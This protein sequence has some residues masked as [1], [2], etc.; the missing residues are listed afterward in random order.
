MSSTTEGY[1]QISQLMS[2]HKELAI[3][4]RFG[5]LNMLNLLHM[6]AELMHLEEKY[7]QISETDKNNPTRAHRSRDWW[8]LTQLDC[9]DDELYKQAFLCGHPGPDAYDLD[10]FREWLTRSTM[11]NFPLRGIDRH[12]WSATY[13]DDLIAL[14]RRESAD[15]F[16]KWFAKT[17][18][19]KFHTLIGHRITT[20]LPTT[21]ITMYKDTHL[22]RILQVIGTVL[23]CLFPITSIVI[24]YLVSSMAA[25]LGILVFFTALFALSLALVTGAKRVEIFAATSAFAAVQVV[26]LSGNGGQIS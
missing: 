13:D 24:L 1:P 6:Q 23:A 16:S 18:V 14:Q 26:F 17:V 7:F 25:R 8:S 22:L 15:V 10:F 4:R 9:H 21:E 20:P 19:P 5:N 3:V 2:K 11:G 12:A